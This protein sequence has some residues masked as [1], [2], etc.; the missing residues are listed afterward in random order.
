MEPGGPDHGAVQRTAER[1]RRRAQPSR[2]FYV[3]GPQHAC[4]VFTKAHSTGIRAP[5]S[6]AGT[7]PPTWGAHSPPC[8]RST[9]R[10]PP[11][12]TS[13]NAS[14]STCRGAAAMTS[15]LHHCGCS[16]PNPTPAKLVGSLG[17][18]LPEYWLSRI[19]MGTAPGHINTAQPI[20]GSGSHGW[21]VRAACTTVCHH[22]HRNGPLMCDP[23]HWRQGK[24][25]AGMAAC[26]RAR[27][28]LAQQ[29]HP[30]SIVCARAAHPA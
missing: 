8:P 27:R 11:W 12:D 21:C 14:S 1:R 13:R 24:R 3:P 20:D 4:A 28:A 29:R 17:G 7:T 16:P 5:A 30:S 15:S 6:R 22:H 25:G 9:R 23:V 2:R 19:D 10:A 26:A 18:P